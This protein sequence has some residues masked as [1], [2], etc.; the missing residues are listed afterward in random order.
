MGIR[1]WGQSPW[2]PFHW[3]LIIHQKS[4]FL[5]GSTM[6]FGGI[7]AFLFGNIN[8][9]FEAALFARCTDDKLWFGGTAGPNQLRG[10]EVGGGGGGKGG[11][12]AKANVDPVR[13]TWINGYYGT[14]LPSMNTLKQFKLNLPLRRYFMFIT[15]ILKTSNVLGAEKCVRIKRY[16]VSWVGIRLSQNVFFFPFLS[17]N[18]KGK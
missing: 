4:F 16:Q 3:C 6:D 8:D 10:M 9:D 5:F 14:L 12:E 18:L 13:F 1:R 2:P 17:Y 11:G 7:R 15:M